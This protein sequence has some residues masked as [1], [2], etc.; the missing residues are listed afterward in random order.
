M[1]R[2]L[3]LISL[4]FISILTF[5]QNQ[6]EIERDV[7]KAEQKLYIKDVDFEDWL[8][9]STGAS[10]I[11]GAN[12]NI[13]VG[14]N[15]ELGGVLT[16]LTEILGAGWAL[17]LGTIGSRLGTFDINSSGFIN[18]DAS[19]GVTIVANGTQYTISGNYIIND[20]TAD[21]LA[22]LSDISTLIDAAKQIIPFNFDYIFSSTTTDSRPGQGLFRLNNATLANVTYIYI[23]YFDADNI[24]KNNYFS[25]ADTGTYISVISDVNNYANYQV[26]GIADA[27]NYYK[28]RVD[29]KNHNGVISGANTLSFDVNNTTGAGGGAPDSVLV[30]DNDTIVLSGGNLLGNGTGGSTSVDLSFNKGTFKDTVSIG[31]SL[32][33]YESGGIT[34]YDAFYNYIKSRF[35]TI[36]SS[37]EGG[38]SLQAADGINEAYIQSKPSGIKISYEKSGS[39]DEYKLSMIDT[40]MKLSY[41]DDEGASEEIVD[42]RIDTVKYSKPIESVSVTV[43]SIGIKD[44]NG[45][46]S[47]LTEV[48]TSN[49]ISE[50][51]IKANDAYIYPDSTVVTGVKSSKYVIENTPVD[52]VQ[53]DTSHQTY[54]EG[55]IFYCKSDRALSFYNDISGFEHNLGY[56]HVIRFYNNTGSTLTEETIVRSVGTK[57]NSTITFLGDLAGIGSLDSLNGIAMVT[58]DV[59]NN[60]F[61]IATLIGQVN[62]L[63]TSSYSDNQ[64]LYASHAGTYDT[65]SP[66]PPFISQIVGRVVYAD[67]DSGAIYFYGFSESKFD[68]LPIFAASFTGQTQTITNPGQG[69]PALITNGTNDLFTED[70]NSGFTFQ[71]DSVSVL[72]AG[73]YNIAS[74]FSFRGDAASGDLWRVAVFVNGVEVFGVNRTSSSTNVGIGAITKFEE[75]NIG[76]WITFKI[77]NTTNGTRSSV[78][79]DMSINIEYITQ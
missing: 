40:S 49:I 33:I 46:V 50:D 68:P 67:A 45:F 26:T 56:E 1:K 61:G 73:F 16:K 37:R 41:R 77:E 62:G 64:I 43:D 52:K 53:V 4:A 31:D 34:R 29:Y 11:G 69:V 58:A 14:N 51:T 42:F 13:K 35:A 44:D 78:F 27:G 54:S 60:S 18:L 25:L 20:N 5:T 47:W 66:N 38:S 7:I 74:S 65:I 17:R 23:D 75:L 19:S 36:I 57:V 24:A 2:I 55:T 9:D 59:P 28:Y 22:Y 15:I 48:D 12:G 70:I 21:T 6:S 63:N 79:T 30:N 71:G 3:I 8:Q 32:Q 10:V 72:Q 76:D 39:V